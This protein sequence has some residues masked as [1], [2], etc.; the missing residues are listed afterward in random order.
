M[1]RVPESLNELIDLAKNRGGLKSYNELAAHLGVSGPSPSRG[2]KI[3]HG[4]PTITSRILLKWP[5][6]IPT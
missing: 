6:L 5:V 4:R 3:A 2:E 1:R